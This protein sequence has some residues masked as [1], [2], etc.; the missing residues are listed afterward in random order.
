MTDRYRRSIRYSTQGRDLTKVKNPFKKMGS[1]PGSRGQG[2]PE[3]P[4]CLILVDL[5]TLHI[6]TK[7]ETRGLDTIQDYLFLSLVATSLLWR[8]V[9]GKGRFVKKSRN[10]ENSWEITILSTIYTFSGRVI[11]WAIKILTKRVASLG[12]PLVREWRPLNLHGI[13]F[14]RNCRLCKSPQMQN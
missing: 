7:Q 14:Q 9:W 3:P 8:N 4:G 2:P 11:W 12:L 1:G 5:Q 6:T 13:T 10:Q